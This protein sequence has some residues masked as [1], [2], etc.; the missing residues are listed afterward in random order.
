MK[1]LE[2][3]FD[4]VADRDHPR[5]P[6][7]VV[8]LA[9]DRDV[10]PVLGIGGLGEQVESAERGGKAPGVGRQAAALNAPLGNDHIVSPGVDEPDRT[11]VMAG[12]GS[13]RSFGET[14]DSLEPGS[15]R[16]PRPGRVDLRRK[17]A[18]AQLSA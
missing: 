13:P 17:T 16:S 12:G 7:G 1:L 8:L 10:K 3:P 4:H 5:L 18:S 6:V 9:L 14:Q 11:I 15:S 2:M